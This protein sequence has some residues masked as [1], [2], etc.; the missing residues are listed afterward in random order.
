MLPRTRRLA[1]VVVALALISS[2]PVMLRREAV[3]SAAT[4]YDAA[5]IAD[6]PLFYWPLD[7]M[8]A[9]VRDRMGGA[10]ASTSA[11]AT[12]GVSGTSGT[13]ARFDGTRQSVRDTTA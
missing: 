11:T 2:G 5:V 3:A 6:R 10:S 4:T 8:T 9:P 7:E 13:A 1:A 12:L